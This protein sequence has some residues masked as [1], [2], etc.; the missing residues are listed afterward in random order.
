MRSRI[1]GITGGNGFIG[2]HFLKSAIKRGYRP[3]VLIQTGTSLKSVAALEG[4]YDRIYGDLNHRESLEYFVSQCDEIIHLGG[5][6]RYWSSDPSIFHRVNVEGVRLLA[7]L[8]LK[9]RIKK[10]LHVSSCITLGAAIHPRLRNEKSDYNLYQSDFLYG[11]TKKIGEVEIKRLIQSEGLPAIIVN[12]ASVLGEQD[13]GPTPIGRVIHDISRGAWPI[14]VSGGSCFIDIHDLIRGLWL[15]LDLAKVG[16]QYLLVGENLTNR[17]FMSR[18]AQS[19]GVSRGRFLVPKK[20][21]RL[22][23]S[24]FEA[25]SDH[26]TSQEPIL[27]Q[28]A[29][30]LIGRYLYYDGSLAQSELGFNAGTCESAI[31]RSVNWMRNFV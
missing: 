15:A 6:N 24:I 4:Y 27:T 18:V 22:A 19:A 5:Y 28:G 8:C 2:S 31:E 21:L 12:P 7:R 26:L 11:E 9:Y 10:L 17:E 1:I 16:S 23:A 29:A 20:V 13:Y 30:S 3:I 25:I 14:Y